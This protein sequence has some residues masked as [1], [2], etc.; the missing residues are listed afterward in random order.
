MDINLDQHVDK[1]IVV[2]CANQLHDNFYLI[3]YPSTLIDVV[4]D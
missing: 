1:F 2:S 3:T 4:V